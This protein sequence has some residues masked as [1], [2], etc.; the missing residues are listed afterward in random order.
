MKKNPKILFVDDSAAIRKLVAFTLKFRQFDIELAEHGKEAWK[1]LQTSRPDL[2]ITDI[3]M[4]EMGGFELISKIKGDKNLNSI[5]IV[6]L[7]TEGQEDQ[8][9]KGEKLGVSYYL[10]KPFEPHVL[11]EVVE[12]ALG[13]ESGTSR[14]VA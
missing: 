14:K 1:Q 10:K 12:K 8:V 5:P 13:V 2:I 7:T 9:A 3:L 11:I 6:V 4:P